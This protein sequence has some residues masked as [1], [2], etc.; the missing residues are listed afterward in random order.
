[1]TSLR[2]TGVVKVYQIPWSS[3]LVDDAE[4]FW[5]GT[6]LKQTQPYSLLNKKWNEAFLPLYLQRWVQ[7]LP[8]SL[9]QSSGKVS[10]N[11]SYAVLMWRS[12]DWENKMRNLSLPLLSSFM[13]LGR[14]EV[15]S[16]FTELDDKGWLS[17]HLWNLVPPWKNNNI[18]H[19]KILWH[20]K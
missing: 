15:I 14:P 11:T 3:S 6:K 5:S 20:L 12:S 2:G 8:V 4:S 17:K 19:T 7:S 1:M 18:Y 9:L 16:W 10:G 13:N